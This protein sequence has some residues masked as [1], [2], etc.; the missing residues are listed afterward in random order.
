[1]EGKDYINKAVSDAH[2]QDEE[3][4]QLRQL[5]KA[6]PK[7]CANQPGRPDVLQHTIYSI[8][9]VPIKERPKR[10]SVAKQAIVE[11][12]LRNMVASGVVESSHSGWASPVVLPPKNDGGHR[13][14]V[15]FWK[16]NSVT[17]TDSSSET[18]G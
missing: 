3:K 14:C 16:I 8:N 9:C 15:D 11:E 13:F 10:M 7:V 17:E 2:L 1:M 18:C 5:L 6:K 4:K 12:Q